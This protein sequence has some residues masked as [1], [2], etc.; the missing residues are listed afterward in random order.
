MNLIS[1][2]KEV[3]YHGWIDPK[4]Q[5]PNVRWYTSSRDGKRYF[6]VIEILLL[7]KLVF[8]DGDLYVVSIGEY[9]SMQIPEVWRTWDQHKDKNGS[10]EAG[11]NVVDDVVAWQYLPPI[12]K[13]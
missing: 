10:H 4:K 13:E 7:R 3:F 6:D 8:P 2:E 9:D 12:P 5:L 1:V 11:G